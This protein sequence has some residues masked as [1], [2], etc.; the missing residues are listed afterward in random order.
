MLPYANIFYTN[1]IISD[2]QRRTN[3]FYSSKT[4]ER[5]MFCPAARK[6][7]LNKTNRYSRPPH[8]TTE[9]YLRRKNPTHH[10]V[11]HLYYATNKSQ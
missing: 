9:K 3:R 2:V 7:I 10:F 11:E 5:F 4:C 8:V 6:T 1:Y